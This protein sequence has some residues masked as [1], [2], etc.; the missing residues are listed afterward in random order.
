MQKV[1]VCLD[2]SEMSLRAL[3][4]AQ[5]WASSELHLLHVGPISILDITQTHLP[6]GGDDL[7]PRQVEERLH[8][9]GR[10]ILDVALASL[11]QTP[12]K[13]ETHLILGHPGDQICELAKELEVDCVV[14]SS[15][16]HSRVER[17]FLGSVSDY[18]VRHCQL[19][20][21]VIK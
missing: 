11:G 3:H 13:V 12:L 21:L 20:V 16:G 9:K 2:G 5:Q 1:L 14:I 10:H 7:L 19:P 18:V 4:K 15:R 8:S 17:V 6:M